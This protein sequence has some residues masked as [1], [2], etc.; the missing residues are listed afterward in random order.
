MKKWLSGFSVSGISVELED[1]ILIIRYGE[2][3]FD[4]ISDLKSRDQYISLL[5]DYFEQETEW[6]H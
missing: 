6:I 5:H 4:I 3:I 1:D 2:R